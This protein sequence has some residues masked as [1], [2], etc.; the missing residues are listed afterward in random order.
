M[1]WNKYGEFK[2]NIYKES[3]CL[4]F[5]E[6]S[7]TQAKIIFNLTNKAVFC[8]ENFEMMKPQIPIKKREWNF[9]FKFIKLLRCNFRVKKII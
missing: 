4:L 5:I 2:A 8:T 7:L 3:G 1:K 9:L 6:S